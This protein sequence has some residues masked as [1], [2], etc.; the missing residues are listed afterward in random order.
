MERV[1][2]GERDAA[3]KAVE[4]ALA[5]GRIVQAD[6]DARVDQLRHARTASELQMITQDLAHRGTAPAWA[7]YE[8]PVPATEVPRVGYGPPQ[9]QVVSAQVRQMYGAKPAGSPARVL[10]LV[11]IV[12]F[13]VMVV[14]AGAVVL[15]VMSG[16]DDGVDTTFEEFDD[17]PDFPDLPDFPAPEPA[18]GPRLLTPAGFRGLLDAIDAETGSTTAYEAVL[19]PD[20]AVTTV[21]AQAS[22][23]RAISYYYDGE[24]AESTRGTAPYARFDLARIDPAV[25]A[26]LIRKARGLVDDPTSSYVI[27]RKP[28]DTSSSWLAAY[29]SNEFG[30]SAYLRADK[31]GTVVDRSVS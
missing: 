20:Y 26:R 31:D 4:A 14:G 28:Q 6:R 5:D 17:F 16:V 3:I 15:G 10:L 8:P 7:T 25:L 27:V 21:P 12:F 22:G 23:T 13:L 9:E 30:E 29:A 2:D 1:G 24:L 18:S 19:Y 11:P